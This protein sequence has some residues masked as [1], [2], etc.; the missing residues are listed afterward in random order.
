M[1]HARSGLNAVLRGLVLAFGVASLAQGSVVLAQEKPAPSGAATGK[2]EPDKQGMAKCVVCHDENYRYPVLSILKTKH[3]VIADKRT[4]FADQACESCHGQGDD[5]INS[6]SSGKLVPPP[7]VFGR[8]SATTPEMQNK[9]CL[10]CHQSGLRMHWQGSQ[11]ESEEVTC[12]SCHTL[13]TGKDKV[14]VKATQPEVCF[15]CH[16]AQRSQVNALS[17]HPIKEGKTTCSQ[18]HNPHG[19]AGPK[20]LVKATLNDTCYTCHAEKRGPFLWEHAPVREDCSNC[21][22]PHGSNHRP[23]LKVRVPVLCQQCH[24]GDTH[25]STAFSGTGIPPMGGA[26]QLLGKGCTNCHSQVHGS[27]HPSGARLT[28]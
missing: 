22:T 20:M 26:K 15:A 13:H 23:L 14:L 11:H 18:C 1:R 17:F 5:H 8:K 3:A 4:P 25:Q 2:T 28:R 16:K 19:S 24:L 10:N 21:H 7:V 6:L 9:Q 12:V 27:N